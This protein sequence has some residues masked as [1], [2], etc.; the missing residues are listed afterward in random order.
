MVAGTAG[1]D[2]A[3]V[4]EQRRWGRSGRERE[5]QRG[6]EQQMEMEMEMEKDTDREMEMEKE[7]MREDE[8]K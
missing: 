3:H 7:I 1:D 2:M 6:M 5:K 4:G 8:K